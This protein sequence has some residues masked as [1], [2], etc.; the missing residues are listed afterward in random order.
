MNDPGL[1]T[2]LYDFEIKAAI[3]E[4]S[5]IFFANRG[6]SRAY[7][8]M[9]RYVGTAGKKDHTAAYYGYVSLNKQHRREN[10][11]GSIDQ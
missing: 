8:L 10:C 1:L 9:E 5:L 6:P 7:K 11:P 2:V 3:L 4:Q